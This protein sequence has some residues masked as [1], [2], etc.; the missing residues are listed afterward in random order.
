MKTTFRLGIK[1]EMLLVLFIFYLYSGLWNVTCKQTILPRGALPVMAH[2]GGLHPK[3][4]PTSC[5]LVFR[6][7]S[8]KKSRDFLSLVCMKG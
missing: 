5:Y 8:I 3:G 4:V 2:V 6:A 1:E 7:S